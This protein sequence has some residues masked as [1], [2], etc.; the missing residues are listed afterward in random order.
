MTEDQMDGYILEVDLDY[1][2]HLHIEHNSFPLAPD[3]IVVTKEDMSEYSKG[4]Q[5]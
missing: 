5:K 1:P 2:E 3:R 4:E